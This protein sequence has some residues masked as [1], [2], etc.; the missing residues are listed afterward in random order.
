MLYETLN[1]KSNKNF[2]LQNK[3]IKSETTTAYLLLIPLYGSFIQFYSRINLYLAT[4]KQAVV[5][6]LTTLDIKAVIAHNMVV[7]LFCLPYICCSKDF[8]YFTYGIH[9]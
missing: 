5:A 4:V 8:F 6:K 3:I 1:I 7:A 9:E 2:D